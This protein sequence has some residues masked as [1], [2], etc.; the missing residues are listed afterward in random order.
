MKDLT[1]GSIRGH[2]LRLATPIMVGMLVQTLYFLVDLYFVSRLGADAL[3]GVSMAGNAVMVTIALTQMLS[4]ATV[5]LMS[6]A[7]GAKDRPSG[8][9]SAPSAPAPPSPRPATS[10]CCGTCPAWRCST[11]WRR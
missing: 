10:T 9:T 7:V 2:L 11:R 6:H 8:P 4:A 3:A 1:R 5:V